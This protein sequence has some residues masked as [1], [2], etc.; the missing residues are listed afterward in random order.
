[1]MPSAMSWPRNVSPE[2]P[3]TWIYL[4]MISKRVTI[5]NSLRSMVNFVNPR[6]MLTQSISGSGSIERLHW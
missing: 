2:R 5:Q 3:K 1:M 4:E 6:S